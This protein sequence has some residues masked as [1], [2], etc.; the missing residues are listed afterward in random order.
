MIYP[1]HSLLNSESF[2]VEGFE[3]EIVEFQKIAFKDFGVS[4]KNR[5]YLA[6]E[7]NIHRID[8]LEKYVSKT[9]DNDWSMICA[10][11]KYWLDFINS[12]Q[13]AVDIIQKYEERNKRSGNFNIALQEKKENFF[14]RFGIRLN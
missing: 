10:D 13:N 2:F 9:G 4:A 12:A 6:I 14:K 8:V 1:H 11:K 3:F 5:F 7:G